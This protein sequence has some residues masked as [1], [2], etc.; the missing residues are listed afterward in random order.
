MQAVRQDREALLRS[1]SFRSMIFVLM[2]AGAIWVALKKI[3]K[4]ELAMLGLALLVLIDMFVVDK[5]LLKED[6]FTRDPQRA[7]F[8]ETEADKFIKTDKNNHYR[9]LYLQ[10]PFNDARTSYHHR[11]IGGYHGAKMK[12]YQDL[13][14]HQIQGEINDLIVKLRQGNVNFNSEGVLNMLD[15]RY[16]I[17][18]SRRGEVIGNQAANGAAWFIQ[19]VRKVSTP[20]EELTDTGNANTKVIAVVNTSKF[21]IDDSEGYFTGG[22]IDLVQNKPNHLIYDVDAAGNAFAVFSE[23][24]YPVGW[25]ATIDGVEA[26]IIQAN[27]VLRALEIPEGKHRVEFKFAPDS[28]TTGNKVMWV[29]NIILILSFFGVGFLE[30][31]TITNE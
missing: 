5:R 18:G 6:S 7:F 20:D 30:W 28:Y 9:V 8:A 12:R 25:T 11:S 2:A 17:A 10:N 21:Q 16:F 31:R 19:Q 14:E 29:A 22:T 26:E 4:P 13:I 23:I 3:V 15:A 24:Y 27:Y 1:D